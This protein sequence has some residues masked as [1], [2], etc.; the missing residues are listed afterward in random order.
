MN[1]HS[2]IIHHADQ[3]Q[4]PPSITQ[5]LSLPILLT[6]KIHHA[7]NDAKSFKQECNQ[8]SNHVDQLSH[9]LRS[10]IRFNDSTAYLYDR[11]VR[12]IYTDLTTTLNRAL[13]LVRKCRRR[14]IFRRFVS[15]VSA[16]DF[17]KVTNL[18]DAS[19]G[20]MKWLL[21]IFDGAAG[22]SDGGGGGVVLTL[23]PVANNDPILAWIWSYILS[24]Y[25]SS[26]DV[27]MEAARELAVLARDSERNKTV[28]VEEGGISPLLKLLHIDNSSSSGAQVA[29]AVAL[30]NLANDR[31]RAR[32]IFNEH[33]VIIVVNVFR[34][35]G[36]LVQI[37]V[38]KL[39]ARM[40]EFDTVCQEAFAREDVVGVVVMLLAFDDEDDYS[41][42]GKYL[43]RSMGS[44]DDIY[45]QMDTSIKSYGN[46]RAASSSIWLRHKKESKTETPE[47][48]LELKTNCSRALWML[49]KG[50]VANC[51]KITETKG[52]LCLAKLIEK[53]KGELQ[54]NCLMT[55]LE[56]TD[57]AE[58]HP[59]FRRAAFKTSSP[60][61]K[62]IAEQLVKQVH[63]SDTHVIVIP[64]VRAIGHLARTFPARQTDQVIRPL[65]KQLSHE[66]PDVA[67]ESVIALGKFTCPD[68]FLCAEHS[69]TVVDF[70]GVQPVMRLL[71]GSDRTQ[72]HA[73]ALLCYI[74]MHAGNCQPVQQARLLTSLEGAD[75]SAAC[76]RPEL[77]ELVTKAIY[78]LK[79][80]SAGLIRPQNMSYSR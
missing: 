46:R 31:Y 56:I 14:S 25:L 71:R 47:M 43:R 6:D 79:M 8:I 67:T 51:R 53:E 15:I 34:N 21:N 61:A 24:L 59:E 19:T 69:K 57:A 45:H 73:L 41:K 58:C 3:P 48:I 27:K 36:I 76:Q 10:V 11:P 26:L 52:L 38:A 1:P 4:Q 39:I 33:G 70:E 49:A 5:I 40:A 55:V 65:V 32:L 54:I 30:F 37:E 28:I 50:N 7:V 80:S 12:R 17:R 23:P 77:R 44:L 13:S 42:C 78:H 18:L 72:Y 20:D 75:K 16:A 74:A 29:G 64:A 22:D 66:N 63:E 68:N 60:A 35:S 9:L 2:L 62:A